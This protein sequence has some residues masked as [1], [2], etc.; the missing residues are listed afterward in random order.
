MPTSQAILIA[1]NTDSQESI[2]EDETSEDNTRTDETEKDD[3]LKDDTSENGTS[4]EDTRK[5]ST[6]KEENSETNILRRKL[7]IITK[8]S[9]KWFRQGSFAYTSAYFLLRV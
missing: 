1:S 5:D 4:E 2:L 8:S 7:A 9:G 6:G 3:T